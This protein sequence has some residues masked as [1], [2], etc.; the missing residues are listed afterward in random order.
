MDLKKIFILFGIL[1][2]EFLFLSKDL[3]FSFDDKIKEEDIAI[4]FIDSKSYFITKEGVDKVLIANKIRQYKSYK[5]FE[6]PVATFYDES[7][8]KVISSNIAKYTDKNSVVELSGDVNI[9]YQDKVLKTSKLFY[10]SKKQLV[11]DSQ[12][13]KLSA[14]TFTAYGNHLY[15]DI[16]KNLIKAKNIKFII[17]E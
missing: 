12:K 6:K 17:R 15:F 5:E 9:I 4:E 16:N 2:V 13:F 1:L 7:G 8:D 14:S 3:K 11:Y 10:N